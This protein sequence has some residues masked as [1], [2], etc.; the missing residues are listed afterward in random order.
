VDEPVLKKFVR[1]FVLFLRRISA[2]GP[3][4]RKWVVVYKGFGNNLFKRKFFSY[5]KTKKLR[6]FFFEEIIFFS[7]NIK[8]LLEIKGRAYNGCKSA[9]TRRKK[10]TTPL[11][12]NLNF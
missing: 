8:A 10:R 4:T 12:V 7:F 1:F 2:I 9:K 5:T 11:P 6:S 3:Q